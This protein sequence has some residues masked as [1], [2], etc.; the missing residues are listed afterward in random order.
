MRLDAYVISSDVKR[1]CIHR[2]QSGND[3]L[4]LDPIDNILTH[5]I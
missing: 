4:P 5:I 3:N 1:R 2:W